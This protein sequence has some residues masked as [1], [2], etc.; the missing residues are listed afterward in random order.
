MRI[1]ISM[2][3]SPMMGIG[4]GGFESHCASACA[5]LL[6]WT[7]Q[8]SLPISRPDIERCGSNGVAK[9]S[10]KEPLSLSNPVEM[11][12]SS[13][14]NAQSRE[15]ADALIARGNEAEDRGDYEAAL[16]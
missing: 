6:S 10:R 11:P 4:A 9:R 14:E 5:R 8:A 12:G 13:S 3:A 1:S 16:G 7:L 15:A 2:C